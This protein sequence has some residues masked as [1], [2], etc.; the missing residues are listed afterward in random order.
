[1]ADVGAH[2]TFD[3]RLGDVEFRVDPGVAHHPAEVDEDRIA[4]HAGQEGA[5][6]VVKTGRPGA[7]DG[8]D[9]EHLIR[10]QRRRGQLEAMEAVHLVHHPQLHH[11]VLVVV[12]RL[13]V[14]AYCD[15]DARGAQRHDRRD[16]VAHVEVAARMA[17]DRDAAAAH[18]LDFGFG[19]VNGV[20][21]S[22]M[23]V[24]ETE[25]VEPEHCWL[26]MPAQAVGLLHRRL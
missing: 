11:R 13:V 22:D 19:N 4:L 21:I 23:A 20:A 10:A 26:A 7:V 24:D 3:E 15:I 1:V 14:E 25:I 5:D 17:G 12:D 16:A 2:S 18:Q 6:F 9:L 8:C